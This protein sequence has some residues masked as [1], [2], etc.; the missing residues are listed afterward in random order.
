MKLKLRG[1]GQKDNFEPGWLYAI[2]FPGHKGNALIAI[3]AHQYDYEFLYV[4]TY[5]RFFLTHENF[6][7]LRNHSLL[8]PIE[9]LPR[10]I[11][12]SICEKNIDKKKKIQTIQNYEKK[13]SFNDK[14]PR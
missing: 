14:T 9:K 12:Q 8:I 6:W 1:R 4:P 11:F 3:Q 5:Q 7:H 10:E 2:V 13:E